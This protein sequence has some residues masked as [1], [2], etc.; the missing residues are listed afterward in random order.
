VDTDCNLLFG[1][2]ALQADLID[3]ARFAEACS[4]WAARKDTPLAD[5]L[6]E[7]GWLSPDDRADVER[8]LR[9]KL[10]KH[11]GDARAGLAEVTTDSVKH[12]LLGLADADVRQSLAG[13]APTPPQG[14]VLLATTAPEAGARDRYTLSRLHATGGIGRVWLARDASLGRDVALKELRPE[15]AGNPEVW[16]RFLR[17]AQITGQLEHPGIVPIYEVGRSPEDQAPF[18]TM[19]FVRGRTLAETV[20]AYHQRRSRNEAGPLELRELL[21]VFVGVCNAAAYAHSRGV[22]HRDLKPQ[23]VVLG[24]YGEVIVLDW[25][26]AK[27]MGQSEDEAAPLQLP[28]EGEPEATMQGSVLGTPAYMAPEQAEGR[29]DLLGPPTDV[30][31]LGAILYEVLTGKPPFTGGETENVLSRVIHEMPARPRSLEK[32]APPALEAVCLKALAKKPS[33]R[34]AT[35]KELAAE[36]QRWLADE[37]VTAW[38]EPLSRRVGRWARRHRTGVAVAG[39]LLVAG[40]AALGVSTVLVNRQRARAEANFQ[41]ARTAVDDMYTEVAEKWLAQ[42]SRMEPVQREF[43]VKALRFYEQ[44]AQPEGSSPEVRLEAGKAARRVGA[45]QGRL[46]DNSAADAAFR[47]SIATLRAL[48]AESPDPAVRSELQL[49]LNRYAWLLWSVGRAP[50]NALSEARELGESLSQSSSAPVEVRA[51]LATTYSVQAIVALAYGRFADAEEAQSRAVPL[52]EAIIKDY[53]TVENREALGRSH[54]HRARLFQRIGRFR[55]SE[56]EFNQAVEVASAVTTDA[57]RVPRPRSELANDLIERASLLSLFARPKEAETDLRRGLAL[58]DALVADFPS[59]GDYRELQ[60]AIR[61]DLAGLLSDRRQNDEAR[62]A[63]AVAIADGEALVKEYPD[64]V[65]YRWNLCVHLSGLTSLEW[66]A[67]H[68]EE[69]ERAARRAVELAEDISARV[70]NRVDYRALVAHRR[71]ELADVLSNFNRKPEAKPIYQRC[72]VEYEALVRECPGVPE[73]R[74]SLT[75][76]LTRIGDRHRAVGQFAEAQ[77]AYDRSLPLAEALAHDYPEIPNYLVGPLAVR[78]SLAKLAVKQGHA[79]RAR[80]LLKPTLDELAADLEKSPEHDYA[81]SLRS[82]GLGY[83][84]RSQAL[85]GDGRAATATAAQLEEFAQAALERFNAACYL[86]LLFKDV[87]DSAKPGPERD[88]LL[89]TLANRSITQLRK[90][91]ETGLQGV[92]VLLDDPDFDPIRSRE[93]FK[94]LRQEMSPAKPLEKK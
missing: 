18:Y 7:R 49:S 74:Y 62:Q 67:G 29:L 10:D 65:S 19:R 34:Y 57:P 59:V 33:E 36:V 35:A 44:F 40:V 55:E 11:K 39:A 45:I 87:Q 69:A 17:E 83:L 25:G 53:P 58:T 84:A 93:E 86:S 85:E 89:R 82:T 48:A 54:Y 23:N 27:V 42:E 15:R 37:P 46:G 14:L 80:E 20:A 81:H 32:G 41:L 8:L 78:I 75:Q 9:R 63:Y 13:L 26:L 88:A 71:F 61:R 50:D 64:Y 56:A 68:M 5:L 51:E 73:Y 21:A 24:D 12:S 43:L 22:L 92:G 30:Y 72:L 2:L 6:V 76:L 16:A 3:P 90:A 38:K 1:V 91:K 47:S 28:L 60:A 4:A 52:R 79:A 70:P 77:A 94:A 66:G 31:G